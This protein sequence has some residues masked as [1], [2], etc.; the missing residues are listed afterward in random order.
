MASHPNPIFDERQWIINVRQ[1]LE[2]ENEDDIEIPVCIF[3]VPK[4]LTSI[5]PHS[6]TPQEVAIGPYHYWRPE[7]YEMERYK[8]AAAK[9]VQRQ[10]QGDHSFEYVVGQLKELELQ[11]R[12]CYHKYLNFSNETLA[13]M[14]AIDASFLLELL[15]ICPLK[16]SKLSTTFL[17]RSMSHLVDYPGTK[18]THTDDML[19]AML[20]AFCEQAS[21]F[22]MMKNKPTIPVSEC[23]HL[24]NFLYDTIVPKSEQ[25]QPEITEIEDQGGRTQENQVQLDS[26]YAKSIQ[27]LL[28][29][30]RR[31]LS[32]LP[33][34][35]ILSQ[36]IQTLV[37]PTVNQEKKTD[38]QSSS[39]KKPPSMEEI[40]IPSVTELCQSNV[41]FS[42][43]VGSISTISFNTKTA[44]LYLP[45]ISLDVNSEVILRNL[46]AYEASTASEPLVFTR[47]TELINV[48]IDNAEDSKL[49]REKGIIS[50]RLKSDSDVANLWNGMSKPISLTKVPHLD[51]VI[52]DVNKYYSNR[53]KIKL[54]N[55]MR[56]YVFGSWQILTL[57]ATIFFLG[58]TIWQAFCSSY[59]CHKFNLGSDSE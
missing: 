35:S 42:A 3:N 21:P 17:S 7:L 25:V 47:Y 10:L 2:E 26:T 46:V 31:I 58:L 14:M 4:T 54:G 45:K 55:Y 48:I 29:I 41:Q 34:F 12:A 23:A 1:T 15:Q 27:S 44:T 8:L 56:H 49:L 40:A 52:V 39:V 51:K 5:D 18:A 9:R 19:R 33:G 38:Q 59:N 22:K 24:L 32:K 57:L 16:E 37:F 43:T 53:W 13:W 11:I 28:Q 50:S 36:Q 20:I 6:Y 30:T